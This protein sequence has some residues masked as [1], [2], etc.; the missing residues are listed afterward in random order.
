MYHYIEEFPK[1]G[2]KNLNF[3]YLAHTRVQ[4]L[5]KSLG[6]VNRFFPI[7]T[8]YG[9]TAF[10]ANE[11]SDSFDGVYAVQRRFNSNEHESQRRGS[12]VSLVVVVAVAVRNSALV[13][14]VLDAFM[15]VARGA[16]K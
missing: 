16:Y 10:S 11:L 12:I 8:V 3:I 2:V 13:N 9:K 4:P 15:P 6:M 7:F 14:A 5:L 1:N